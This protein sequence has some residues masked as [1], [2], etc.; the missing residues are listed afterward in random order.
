MVI[1]KPAA[2]RHD[3]RP[4][5]IQHKRKRRRDQV[6]PQGHRR[7]T[8]GIAPMP[9]TQDRHRI[10]RICAKV[11][12]Q[13]L[14]PPRAANGID[15]AAQATA[16]LKIKRGAQ[17]RT[18]P[19][20]PGK[21]ARACDQP[22]AQ[23]QPAA[24]PR[25]KDDPKGRSMPPPRPLPRLCQGKA[26]GIIQ[27]QNR[28]AKRRVNLFRQDTTIGA[29]DIRHLDPS[30]IGRN[31]PCDGNRHTAQRAT[32]GK[33]AQHLQKG[34]KIRLGRDRLAYGR[35]RALAPQRRLDPRSANVETQDHAAPAFHRAT[36]LT[37]RAPRRKRP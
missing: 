28:Q 5:D 13:P 34:S 2:H 20:F 31:H 15:T 37:P 9:A 24:N 14:H 32:I 29:G 11:P 35:K 25:A 3:P 16:A 23:H 7:T 1:R 36:G 12:V 21:T 33:A 22:P 4:G 18:M 30:A 26:I 8:G 27:H 10:R 6:K 19:P 17:H